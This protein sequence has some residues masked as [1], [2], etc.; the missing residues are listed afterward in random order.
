MGRRAHA[1]SRHKHPVCQLERPESY[2][3]SASRVIC[4]LIVLASQKISPSPYLVAT[5]HSP[6]SILLIQILI[7]RCFLHIVIGLR[8]PAFQ[9]NLSPC[10]P[11]FLIMSSR[12]ETAS[13]EDGQNDFNGLEKEE[14]G[15]Q[16]TEK[17]SAGASPRKLHGFSVHFNC[18]L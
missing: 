17:S 15:S 10:R 3:M 18:L 4:Q 7:L 8:F 11:Y 1:F 13:R 9:F 16:E 5:I 6:P 2:S 14:A 12:N